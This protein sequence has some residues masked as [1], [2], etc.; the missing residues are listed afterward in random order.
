MKLLNCYHN[1][2]MFLIVTGVI[3]LSLSANKTWAEQ[4]KEKS[5]KHSHTHHQ[6]AA[7]KAHVHGVAQLSVVLENDSSGTLVY[8]GPSETVFGFDHKAVTEKEKKAQKEATKVLSD[9]ASGLFVFDPKLNCRLGKG[10]VEVLFEDSHSDHQKGEKSGEHSEVRATWSL[11][12]Q[13]SVV[14][15]SLIINM[16]SYFSRIENLNVQFLSSKSQSELKLSK[17]RGS[18]NLK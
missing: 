5:K 18:L 4:A 8:E 15:S 14:G 10:K 17:G 11:Q 12:C 13:S 3:S 16:G 2:L 1:R 9:L 7:P 6:H